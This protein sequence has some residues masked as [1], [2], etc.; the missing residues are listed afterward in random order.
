[1]IVT[2]AGY[3]LLQFLWYC[4]KKYFVL[5]RGISVCNNKGPSRLMSWNAVEQLFKKTQFLVNQSA[6][7][8]GF[9]FSYSPTQLL[10]AKFSNVCAFQD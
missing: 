10:S 9:V 5:L 3:L 8:S 4:R 1:M 7:L 6:I 2:V